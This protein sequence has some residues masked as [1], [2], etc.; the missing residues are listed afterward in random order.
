M[1]DRG[2]AN[3]RP[4]RMADFAHSTPTHSTSSGLRRRPTSC[5]GRRSSGAAGPRLAPQAETFDQGLVARGLVPL[6]VVEQ[7]TSL[8]H[9][10]QQPAPRMVILHVGLEVLG[11]LV[12]ALASGARPGPRASRCPCRACDARRRSAR[13]LGR[14]QGRNPL[15]G[16][17]GRSSQ[18]AE[19]CSAPSE[20]AKVYQSSP[21]ASNGRPSTR[22]RVEP[23]VRAAP[24]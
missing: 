6:E 19:A 3:R 22:Q 5:S 21:R 17:C 4:S 8:A 15:D 23:A 11:Q 7:A 10:L 13:L 2:C 9:Q 24:P 16:R 14:D 18:D 20:A 1:R 12:D